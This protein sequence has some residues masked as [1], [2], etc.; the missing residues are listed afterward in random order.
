MAKLFEAVKG[1]RLELPVLVGAFYGM[2][3]SE[4]LG[5]RWNAIDFERGTIT[6]KHTVTSFNLDGKHVQI[7]QDSAKSKSSIRTLPLVGQFR[8]YFLKVKEAQ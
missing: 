8:E 2:R 6:V 1:H 4:V 7:E 5:L 3:R